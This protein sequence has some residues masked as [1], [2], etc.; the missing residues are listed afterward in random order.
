MHPPCPICDVATDAL[1]LCT[2]CENLLRWFRGHFAHIPDLPQKIT[3]ET[4]FVHDLSVDSLDWMSWP[5]EAEQTFGV[6][7]PDH[8]CERIQTVGQY[9]RRLRQTGA[10]WP[11]DSDI[12]LIP[13]LHWWSPYNYQ[14]VPRQAESDPA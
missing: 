5:W 7:L 3:P 14:V 4:H 12:R 13:R 9:L 11:E 8:E 1:G 6:I 2:P 10:R